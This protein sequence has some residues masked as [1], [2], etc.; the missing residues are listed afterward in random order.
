MS[1]PT[2]SSVLIVTALQNIR[3]CVILSRQISQ[4]EKMKWTKLTGLIA[5]T[6]TPFHANGSLNLTVVQPYAQHLAD[7]GIKHIYVNG[8]TG[9]FASLTVQ[10]RKEVAEA[11]IKHGR[12]KL[13]RIIVQC[14]SGNL[15]ETKDLVL[16]ASSIGADCVAVVSPT[17]Y[18]PSNQ[19]DLITYMTEAAKVAPNTPFMFY[20]NPG[21]TGVNVNVTEFLKE[22]HGKIPNLIAVKFG[23]NS[24]PDAMMASEL[25]DRYYDIHTG[26]SEVLGALA[27]GIK[28]FIG[29]PFSV[30][31]KM[32]DRLIKAFEEE[33]WTA[34]R[35]YESQVNQFL[36]ATS[37]KRGD[38]NDWIASMKAIA[39]IYY[40]VLQFGPPRIPIMPITAVRVEEIKAK[41]DKLDF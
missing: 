41:L 38:T 29:V 36:A 28:A 15:T 16:H 19:T 12:S 22:A 32:Y 1:Y 6:Y 26:S 31:G 4:R 3:Q 25:F 10:E 40:P 18:K 14:G 27:M 24:L 2:I 13:D 30:N 33:N 23:T 20:H 39:P 9:E 37:R 5:A 8:T 34:A 21:Q 11:W 35:Q 17:Y 7:I